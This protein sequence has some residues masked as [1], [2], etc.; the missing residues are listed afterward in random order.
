MRL[1]GARTSLSWPG[2]E[3]HGYTGLGMRIGRREFLAAG[4]AV[5]GLAA[6]ET[7]PG[8][9]TATRPN[10]LFFFP[11]QH[12]FDW[13]GWNPAVPVP[14]PNLA[15][16]AARGV[17][18][19]NAIVDSPVCGPSRACL[20]S[21]SVYERC[22]VVNN[23]S[24][25]PLDR[26]T[27]YRA[28]RE[29]GYHVMG[30][31]KLDLHKKDRWWGL[32]GRVSMEPWGFSDMIDN[33][34]KGGGAN[35]YR[36]DPPGPKDPYFAYLDSL[37]PPLGAM[38]ASEIQRLGRVKWNSIDRS[39]PPEVLSD[40]LRRETWWGETDP[41]PLPDEAYCD[42]W[43]A[44][45]GLDL[46]RRAPEGKPWHLVLNFVGPHP[47]MDITESMA[48]RYRGPDR[49][50]EGFGQPEHYDG[51]FPPEQHVRIRQN[52]AAMIENIDR[53]LGV[54]VDELRNRGDFENTLIVYSS[55]HGEMLGDHSRWGKSVPHQ[56]AAGVPLVA[57]GPGIDQG[58]SNDAMASLID[59]T[60]T[61]LDYGEAGSLEWQDGQ[62][63]RP[64]LEGIQSDHR[65]FSRSALTSGGSQWRFVQDRRFKLVEGYGAE[66]VRL[67]DREKDPLEAVNVAGSN[68]SVVE[69]LSKLFVEA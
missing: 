42:N 30:C 29:S 43:I 61:F 57:A 50:I 46:L 16:L 19:P 40:L 7:V 44:R 34:G 26:R 41:V 52:Y 65:E 5:A 27:Y 22:G 10:I 23:G 54:F 59:M 3:L 62:S 63:L 31:G 37:E 11:D 25:F 21:G 12:R 17:N 24:N 32:D 36:S 48:R 14:T 64:I 53:W 4:G 69:R 49:V 28:L 58:R 67:F 2:R 15:E 33:G 68:P 60:A 35:G 66:R 38:W 55:D 47:P 9:R 45:N 1:G 13:V 51:P 20:A 18:F 6:C 39:Q 8:P 56:P